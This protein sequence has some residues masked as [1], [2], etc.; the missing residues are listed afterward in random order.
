MNELIEVFFE[1]EN[2]I[3]FSGCMI[4]TTLVTQMLKRTIKIPTR[5]LSYLLAV[6]ILIMATAFVHGLD[7]EAACL[8]LLNAALVACAANGS[9]DELRELVTWIRGALHDK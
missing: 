4:A 6:A 7:F 2:L 8:I 1:W 3:S 9:F 5:L